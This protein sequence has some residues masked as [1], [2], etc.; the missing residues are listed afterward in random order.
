MLAVSLPVTLP[1]KEMKDLILFDDVVDKIHFV[2][3]Q[4]TAGKPKQNK[5]KTKKKKKA[6]PHEACSSYA[7]IAP[8]T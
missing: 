2:V 6:F 5:E 4:A 7:E 1:I 3:A 8:T